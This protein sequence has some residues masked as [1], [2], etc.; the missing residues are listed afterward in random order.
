MSIEDPIEIYSSLI[1]KTLSPT[2]PPD[3]R[4]LLFSSAVLSNP[5]AGEFPEPGPLVDNSG[6]AGYF[7][8]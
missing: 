6:W 1:Y 3:S 7:S 8:I 4:T 2:P 5:E